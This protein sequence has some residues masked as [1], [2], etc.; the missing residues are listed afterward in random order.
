M[1][2]GG[3]DSGMGLYN[4]GEDVGEERKRK[5]RGGKFAPVSQSELYS[6]PCG[7]QWEPSRTAE[8]L[9]PH[10]QDL[11]WGNRRNPDVWTED[12]GGGGSPGAVDR[13]ATRPVTN[14]H[15]ILIQQCADQALKYYCLPEKR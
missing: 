6:F 2:K 4:R 10:M 8:V 7:A 15:G 13:D 9:L 3:S 11:L 14:T 1:P 12:I 5:K